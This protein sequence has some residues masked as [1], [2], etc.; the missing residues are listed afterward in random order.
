MTLDVSN[1]RE[2]FSKSANGKEQLKRLMC[3]K[4]SHE[5]CSGT[6]ENYTIFVFE[7]SPTEICLNFNASCTQHVDIFIVQVIKAMISMPTM[8]E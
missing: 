2:L 1:C 6:E 5:L 7:F 3:N 8:A 4:W